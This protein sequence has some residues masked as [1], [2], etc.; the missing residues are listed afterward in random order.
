MEGFNLFG[1]PEEFR[2]RLEGLS[3]PRRAG[4]AG[5]RRDPRPLPRGRD[6]G[7]RGSRRPEL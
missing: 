4:D 6:A 7:A 1:D 5:P 2:A 3:E